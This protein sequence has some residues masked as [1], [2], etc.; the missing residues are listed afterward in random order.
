MPGNV[1]FILPSL[2]PE[3][4]KLYWPNWPCNCPEESGSYGTSVQWLLCRYRTETQGLVSAMRTWMHFTIDLWFL[5]LWK[6]LCMKLDSRY[7]CLRPC[8]SKMCL[9]EEQPKQHTHG[10]QK[11]HPS[12]ETVLRSTLSHEPTFRWEKLH[13]DILFLLMLHTVL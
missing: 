6:R 2:A 13:R 4:P 10:N 5:Q 3:S 9:S 12:A 11:P 7:F 8:Y 1:L